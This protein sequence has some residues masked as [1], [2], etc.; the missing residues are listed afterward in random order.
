MI[1]EIRSKVVRVNLTK[2]KLMQDNFNSKA[3]TFK[4]QLTIWEE[5]VICNN[6]NSMK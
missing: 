4:E 1:T 5:K 6:N 2:Q 3:K